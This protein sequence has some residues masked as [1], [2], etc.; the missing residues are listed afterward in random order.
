M[1]DFYVMMSLLR[2]KSFSD[3]IVFAT[4]SLH[5]GLFFLAHTQTC[6]LII[7]ILLIPPDNLV[8]SQ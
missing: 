6:L 7:D 4:L 3:V 8:V 5:V 1:C 2:S